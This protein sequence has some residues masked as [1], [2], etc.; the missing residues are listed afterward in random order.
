MVDL[1]KG[2]EF[3]AEHRTRMLDAGLW[4]DDRPQVWL[5]RWAEEAPDAP[6]LIGTGGTTTYRE[7]YERGLRC[8]N[9]FL[10]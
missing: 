9:A 4:T 8:A 5:R 1:R 10:K 6:A 3:P 7:L 2:A